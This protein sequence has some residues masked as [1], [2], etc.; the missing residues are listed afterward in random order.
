MIGILV[1]IRNLRNK[2][3]GVR[4]E[5]EPTSILSSMLGFALPVRTL[6][7]E[8]FV[9]SRHFSILSICTTSSL[10]SQRTSSRPLCHSACGNHL[11]KQHYAPISSQLPLAA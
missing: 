3:E 9:D 7:K 11:L 10:L 1:K 6:L 5:R 2:C 4:P 8:R